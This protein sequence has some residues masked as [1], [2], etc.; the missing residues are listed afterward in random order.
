MSKLFAYFYLL[1]F[2][3]NTFYGIIGYTELVKGQLKN[4]SI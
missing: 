3:Y 4:G 2:T 1:R